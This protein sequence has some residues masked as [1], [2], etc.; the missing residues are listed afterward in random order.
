[1]I[2]LILTRLG[3]IQEKTVASVTASFV[4]VADDLREVQQNNHA[5]LERIAEEKARLKEE[6]QSCSREALRALNVAK[7]L[8]ELVAE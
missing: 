5:R 7:K 6:E 3:F 8:D 2:K 4:K 1:M